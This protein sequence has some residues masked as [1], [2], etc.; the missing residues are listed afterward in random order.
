MALKIYFGN[1]VIQLGDTAD[2]N[3]KNDIP[4]S[5][6]LQT[7]EED[8][9]AS[10]LE[11]LQDSDTNTGYINYSP[12]EALNALK[13]HFS[14]IE[15][16]GGLIFNDKE[17]ILMIFRRGKWDLPKGKQ[18]EGE[19]LE[20]CALREV[21]EETGVAAHIQAPLTTTYHSYYQGE[22]AIL[23]IAHWFIMRTDGSSVLAPQTDEDI[24][25]CEWVK[26]ENISTYID[27]AH[28]SIRDVLN[29]GLE[30]YQL[31]P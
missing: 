17:E 16:A 21:M 23:K 30:K 7:L 27:G 12:A 29:L 10:F 5:L 2:D 15:A 26:K 3:P 8:K 31:K 22:E 14:F 25:L 4:Q 19:S 1:K 9:L 11:A 13:K 6:S 18:D 24:E 20:Q 28:A